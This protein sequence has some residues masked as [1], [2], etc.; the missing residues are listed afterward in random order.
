MALSNKSLYFIFFYN[1]SITCNSETD[2]W[3]SP[4]DIGFA[5]FSFWLLALFKIFLL[6]WYILCNFVLCVFFTYLFFVSGLHLR[7][8]KVPRLGVESKLQL[9]A[10]VTA[11][12][13][14]DPSPICDL[15]CSSKQCQILN[16]LSEAGNWTHI[17]LDTSRVLNLLNHNGNAE[18]YVY[19][20][21]GT[22]LL[23]C[24]LVFIELYLTHSTLNLRWTTYWPD[25]F[26]L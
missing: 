7:H 8:M 13:T 4:T 20:L 2:A 9:W 24:L 23:V 11:T 18:F 10:Y 15:H 21:K 19:L 26:I 16:S 14:S 22:L 25:K 3:K 6:F 5:D 1:H 17:L 12:A